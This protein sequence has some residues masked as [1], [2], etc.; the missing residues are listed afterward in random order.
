LGYY[1]LGCG[2]DADAYSKHSNG[3]S[4]RRSKLDRFFDTLQKQLAPEPF[5]AAA[6]ATSAAD[7]DVDEVRWGLKQQQIE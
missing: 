5:T 4:S 3:S 6:P 1:T 7:T 2:L